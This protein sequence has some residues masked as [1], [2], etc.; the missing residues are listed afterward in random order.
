MPAQA[1]DR[2]VPLA[3]LAQEG[4]SAERIA[5]LAVSV[6]RDIDDALCPIVGWQGFAALYKRSLHLTRTVHPW[7]AAMQDSALQP[8]RFDA[9]QTALSQQAPPTAVAAHAA[10]LQTFHDLLARLIGAALTARLLQRIHIDA[11]DGSRVHD[12]SP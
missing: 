6:W 1:R 10:L 8:G 7:L 2:D 5:G 4:A 3:Q 9:L 11:V 12:A